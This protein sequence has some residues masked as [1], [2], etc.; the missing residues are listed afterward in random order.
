MNEINK[1]VKS[2][3]T[4]GYRGVYWSNQINKWQSKIVINKQIHL[5]FYSTASEAN[6]ARI[7]YC[8]DN[9]III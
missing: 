3:N 5:G 2:N 6:E 1:D 9:N 7:K 4:S 8:K